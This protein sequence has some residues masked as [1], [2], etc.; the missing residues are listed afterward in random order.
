M[1]HDGADEHKVCAI[2][3]VRHHGLDGSLLL[4]EIP[5][6]VVDRPTRRE[7]I[8]ALHEPEKTRLRLPVLE[9]LEIPD[10]KHG[11]D[12]R[13]LFGAILGQGITWNVACFLSCIL[14]GYK[15][16]GS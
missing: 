16:V 1:A 7:P 8:V 4:S 9:T 6:D 2:V 10:G 13:F 12:P 15:V 14:C 5:T 11:I 3:E